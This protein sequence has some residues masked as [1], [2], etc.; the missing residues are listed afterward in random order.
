MEELGRKEI[1]LNQSMNGINNTAVRYLLDCE[2]DSFDTQSLSELA[3]RTNHKLII[4][5]LLTNE[6]AL[7]HPYSLVVAALAPESL[8]S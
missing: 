4:G 5:K 8:R 6:T 1:G 2:A 7:L 3:S